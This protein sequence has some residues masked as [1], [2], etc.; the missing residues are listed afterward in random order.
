MY[1]IH[2]QGGFAN[3]KS[4]KKLEH[5]N[6]NVK[7]VDYASAATVSVKT[8]T[9][10]HVASAKTAKTDFVLRKKNNFAV[11]LEIRLA[12]VINNILSRWVV[13]N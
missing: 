6:P 11:V 10:D 7:M 4:L 2:F 13:L 1:I 3:A 12:Q 5:V 8:D 9:L